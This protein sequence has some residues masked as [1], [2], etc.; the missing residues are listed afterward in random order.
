MLTRY[1]LRLAR[2]CALALTLHVMTLPQF[3]AADDVQTAEN[4]AL[5]LQLDVSIN[6]Q[7]TGLVAAFTDLG[8][9]RL[10]AT[11]QELGEIGIIAPA[12][13]APGDLVPLDDLPGLKY[14]Y[15]EAKQAIAIETSDVNRIKKNY[16]A[17]GELDQAT[18]TPSD[19]GAVLN[20]TLFG[21][22][23]GD[24]GITNFRSS[25]F[26][27]INATLD[28]RLMAPLGV[29]ENSAIIGMTLA[30]ETETLRLDTTYTFSDEADLV[31]WRAGD[32]IT[33]GTS[34]S[35]PVR[36]GGIQ[37]QRAFSMRPDLVKSPLPA[38]SGS[39]AVPSAVD[40]YVNGVKSFS[41]D[42]AAGPYQIDNI[43]AVTGAGVAQVVTRDASGRETVQS[44]SFYNSPQLL[45]PGLLDFS[46]ETGVARA[47][48]GIE[49]N[50]NSDDIVAS[51]TLR[52]GISDWLTA[53]AHGE[54]GEKLMNGGA[55][56][57]AR[58]SDLGVI[59]A[60]LSGSSSDSGTGSQV[61]GGFETKAG[62]VTINGRSQRAFGDYED[63][64]SLSA[65]DN[66]IRAGIAGVPGIS[67]GFLSYA[68]PRAIDSLTLSTPLDFD[69]GTVSATY[70]RY[71]ANDADTTEIVTASYSRPIFSKANLQATGYVDLNDTD[72]S[73]FF[74]GVSM[75]LDDSISVSSGLS[76][77]GGEYGAQVSA[78]KPVSQK[79]G[80]WGWRITDLEDSSPYR[81]ATVGYRTSAARL[82]A[83]LTQ[84]SAGV[85]T[86]ASAE[87]A[88]AVVGGDVYA[89]NRIEDAFAVVDVHEPDVR[90]ERE[91]VVVGT[92]NEDG[93]ILIPNLNAYQRNKISIDPMDLP[94]NA[95]PA[96][97]Y[98]YITPGFKS[99]VYV[100]FDVKKASQSAL[101][102][103]QDANGALIPPGSEGHLD[104]S[105]EPFVVGY[106]GQAFI[107]DLKA[108]NTVH[109]THEKG[110]CTAQ[111]AFAPTNE[112]QPVIGPEI[113]Q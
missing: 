4:A 57:V 1:L 55:G 92:T 81:T 32:F 46:M 68:P 47:L 49:S 10:A 89:S 100:D 109:I 24:D 59:T 28:M 82:E 39:A 34:W 56:I 30:D 91:N 86:T 103:L 65:R 36:L 76:G 51:I 104:G 44:V 53:E 6:G 20:Y 35:R 101:V 58:V 79:P 108:V 9:S 113:C 37:A 21:S 110:A 5:N 16:N 41:K 112:V 74:L 111:F 60:A 64:A 15:D 84:D 23:G 85:R 42:V 26:S 94:I 43:P 98:D 106:D 45:K 73:G 83:G 75:A 77:R 62:T 66:P 69:K 14:V 25:Q 3:A 48:Y 88:L 33:G 87:G 22:H 38:V 105:E 7:P 63:T 31:R 27:G 80:S 96:T 54:G 107:K 50:A 102:V 97:T 78:S 17:R 71:E 19:Y 52:A 90:V 93:K 11:A 67:T 18:V 2:L 72:S 40:V 70:L 95:E 29:L 99:G 61:Y 12:G 13:K 8:E